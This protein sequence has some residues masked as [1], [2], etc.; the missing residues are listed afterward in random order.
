MSAGVAELR[1]EPLPA[2]KVG[3][4]RVR[5]LFSALSRGTESLVF[6]GK[7]PEAEFTRMRAP[8]MGGDFPFPVKY[9]YASVGR[10]QSGPPELV[11][12]CVFSLSP[13][14]DYF[15]LAADAVMAIPEG[16]HPNEPYWPRIWKPL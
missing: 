7:V 4:V 15:N 10:V 9:G 8:F 14:Q 1:V 5:T 12:R 13:H 16:S 2:L 6:A 3:Q 11:N